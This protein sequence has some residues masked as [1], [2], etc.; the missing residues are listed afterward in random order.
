ML[1]GLVVA[2]VF[3]YWRFV[4]TD[5]KHIVALVVSMGSCLP[6]C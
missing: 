2:Q 6:G 4:K 1:M 3:T 5:K